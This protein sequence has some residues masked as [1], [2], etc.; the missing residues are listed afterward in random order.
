MHDS[1]QHFGRQTKESYPQ[2]F[3][4]ERVL[5]FGSYNVNGSLRPLFNASEYI[6][7]DHRP[8]PGVDKVSLAHAYADHPDG[9]FD[10]VFATSLLEHDPYWH[11]TLRRMADLVKVGG[12]MFLTTHGPEM[13]PHELHCAPEHHFYNGTLKA[14]DIAKTVMERT[15]FNQVVVMDDPRPPMGDLFFLFHR[16]LRA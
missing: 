7:I 16:K 10:T 11:Q 14:V 3:D 12:S 8:G 15:R 6:G 1:V 9:Y 2:I 5:E 13:A 4:C